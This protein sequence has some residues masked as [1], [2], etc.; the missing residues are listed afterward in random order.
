MPGMAKPHAVEHS[1]RLMS[2]ALDQTDAN[3]LRFMRLIWAIDHELER[4][5][6]RMEASH[7]LTVAQRM[8]LLLIGR[9]PDAS[10]A[11]LAALMH[12]HAGTMSGIL[13]RLAAGGFISRTGHESDA[14]R[15]VLT[16]S[17][18]GLKANR[19]RQGT[20]ESTARELLETTSASDIAATERVLSRLADLLRR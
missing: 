3:V 14:R 13:K 5:S 18:K 19:Q 7:G 11:E 16:V 2:D 9:H 15:H 20:F 10:A 1:I 4:V 17:A 12:V 8:T 6:K